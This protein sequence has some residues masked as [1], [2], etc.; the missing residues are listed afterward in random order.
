MM[1]S[2]VFWNE[3]NGVVQC[4]RDGTIN[5][6]ATNAERE[7]RGLKPWTQEIKEDDDE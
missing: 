3:F 7:K 1:K 5:I 2:S 6:D 4:H